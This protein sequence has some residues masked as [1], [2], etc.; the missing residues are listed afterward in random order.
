MV[1]A[2]NVEEVHAT[3]STAHQ[4][5][6]ATSTTPEMVGECCW[7]LALLKMVLVGLLVVDA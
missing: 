1:W 6:E 5:V 2:K 4:H 3:P 7:N